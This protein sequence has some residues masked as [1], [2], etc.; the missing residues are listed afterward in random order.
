M[1]VSYHNVLRNGT[2]D[3]S[4]SRIH[5]LRVHHKITWY[6]PVSYHEMFMSNLGMKVLSCHERATTRYENMG[7][8]T[9]P[10][11]RL[12]KGWEKTLLKIKNSASACSPLFCQ[13]GRVSE[14]RRWASRVALWSV[15]QGEKGQRKNYLRSPDNVYQFHAIVYISIQN[16]MRTTLV[17]YQLGKRV[18]MLCQFRVI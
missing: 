2:L 7:L 18:I 5:H 9:I 10:F 11:I 16:V 8:L 13:L 17:I 12:N 15:S 3:R 1:E 4:L 6:F 14:R